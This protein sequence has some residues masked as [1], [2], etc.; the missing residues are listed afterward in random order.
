M[1]MKNEIRTS[2]YFKKN[3][4]LLITLINKILRLIA[5]ALCL[6]NE[7]I[8]NPIKNFFLFFLSKLSIQIILPNIKIKSFIIKG[9]A[10]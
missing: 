4:S 3:L 8:I 1:K 7:E 6:A 2:L 5:I 10:M 9:T